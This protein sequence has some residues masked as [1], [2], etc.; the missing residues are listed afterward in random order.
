MTEALTLVARMAFRLIYWTVLWLFELFHTQLQKWF[1]YCIPLWPL[2]F[3]SYQE[4]LRNSILKKLM[5]LV[6]F[7][8]YLWRV[9]FCLGRSQRLIGS[10]F[11]ILGVWTA[12]SQYDWS[13]FALN[14]LSLFSTHL[15]HLIWFKCLI[16]MQILSKGFNGSYLQLMLLLLP[17]SFSPLSPSL[18]RYFVLSACFATVRVRC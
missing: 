16:L 9:E 2:H 1:R 7:R 12:E 14:F 6:C 10:S 13:Y 18:L 15:E 11:I 4:A 3:T 5:I 17:S 8:F